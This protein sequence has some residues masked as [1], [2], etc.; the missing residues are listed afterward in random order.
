MNSLDL[1]EKKKNYGSFG[2]GKRKVKNDY[3]KGSY[4]WEVDYKEA[5]RM[6]WIVKGHLSTND[7]TIWASY[8]GYFR[9]V[10]Y[11]YEGRGTEEAE[12]GFEEAF[13][14]KIARMDHD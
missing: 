10:W 9:R 13:A 6:F 2:K 4:G 3:V 1:S 8:D 12:E 14:E 11:D 5:G 7:A